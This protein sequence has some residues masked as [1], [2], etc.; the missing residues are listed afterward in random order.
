[1]T[2]DKDYKNHQCKESPNKDIEIIYSDFNEE[3]GEKK[4]WFH[5]YR[6]AT[7]KDL[8]DGEADQVGELMFSSTIAISFCPFCGKYLQGND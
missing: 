3:T 6:E 7:E 5:I 1:M 8:A 4:W 2:N